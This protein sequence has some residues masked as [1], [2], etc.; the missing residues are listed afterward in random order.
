MCAIT[1]HR[2]V[3]RFEYLVGVKISPDVFELSD[4]HMEKMCPAR[5]H[6]RID[7]AGRRTAQHPKWTG[8]TPRQDFCNRLENPYLIG[9][10]STA[11]A[12]VASA[13]AER[14]TP[15]KSVMEARATAIAAPPPNA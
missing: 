14:P 6:G 8:R 3:I 10:T 9:T 13:F 15:K 7:G 2:P 5:N 11:V 4:T 12:M 1:Y